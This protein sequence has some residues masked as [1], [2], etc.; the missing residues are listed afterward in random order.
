MNGAEGAC[1]GESEWI[2]VITIP[3]RF[4]KAVA[5]VVKN[6][7]AFIDNPIAILVDSVRRLDSTRESRAIPI[8]AIAASG[9]EP[10]TI[11]IGIKEVGDSV[12]V[13]IS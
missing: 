11:G 12:A 4:A 8:I 6:D 13:K 7:G 1:T 10:I 3:C 5:I 2:G 9:G